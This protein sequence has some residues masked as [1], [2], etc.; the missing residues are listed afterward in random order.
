M[1]SVLMETT[2]PLIPHDK[3]DIPTAYNNTVS[4]DGMFCAGWWDARSDTCAGDSGGPIIDSTTSDYDGNAN[5]LVGIVSWGLGCAKPGFP[6][7]YTRI[8]AQY[9][10]IVSNGYCSCTSVPFSGAV[11]VSHAGC[12]DN[13]NSN[14]SHAASETASESKDGKN[15]KESEKSEN[16]ET[17]ALCYV[18]DPERCL[19]AIQS[20]VYQGAAWLPCDTATGVALGAEAQQCKFAGLVGTNF[21]KPS[22]G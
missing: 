12:V 10:W 16:E 1:P 2:L 3:C 21:S 4:I 13:N 20:T 5:R 19:M 18:V 6:G 14:I 7:V 8:D 17:G 22:S 15:S 11:A 9:D